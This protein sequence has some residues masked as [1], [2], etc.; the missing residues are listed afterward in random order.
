MNKSMIVAFVAGA[1]AMVVVGCISRMAFVSPGER[2]EANSMDI[3][4]ESFGDIQRA[5][6]MQLTFV[7]S[8]ADESQKVA[9]SG[10]NGDTLNVY[11]ISYAQGQESIDGIASYSTSYKIVY[12]EPLTKNVFFVLGVTDGGDH[13]IERWRPRVGAVSLGGGG[14]NSS[15]SIVLKRKEIYR[16]NGLGGHSKFGR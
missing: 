10:V 3:L 4:K 1:S 14:P 11:D 5:S 2:P 8:N 16:G 7:S 15:G 9:V 13:V 12:V 6:G